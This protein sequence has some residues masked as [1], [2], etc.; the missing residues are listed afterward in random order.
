MGKRLPEDIKDALFQ[1]SRLTKTLAL[2]SLSN[3]QIK[4][5]CTFTNMRAS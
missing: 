4:D 5:R 1:F 2:G 3:Y